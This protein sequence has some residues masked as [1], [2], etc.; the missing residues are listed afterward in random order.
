ML[1]TSTRVRIQ[2]ILTR[3]S[4]GKKVT[5]AERIYINKNASSNQSVSAWLRKA[6]YLQREKHDTNSTDELL[7]GLDLCSSDPY[8]TFN[9]E[10]DD[11]G[12]WFSGAPSWIRRS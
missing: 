10:Q 12:E 8:S 3:I 4:K 2:E 5:L 1:T 7:N 9:P 6:S 11:L